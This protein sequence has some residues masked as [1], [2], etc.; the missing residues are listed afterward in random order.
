MLPVQSKHFFFSGTQKHREIKTRQ[1]DGVNK[2]GCFRLFL[3]YDFYALKLMRKDLELSKFANALTLRSQS[4]VIV[5]QLT[6]SPTI[7]LLNI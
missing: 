6:T 3:G 2:A 5:Y 4:V 1:A 7:C